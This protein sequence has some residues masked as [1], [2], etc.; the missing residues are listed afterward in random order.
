MLKRV[1]I[2]GI[3]LPRLYIAENKDDLEVAKSSGI[4]YIKWNK[5]VDE[6]V[7]QLL[8]PTL[9]KMFPGILWNKVLGRRRKFKTEVVQYPGG[10]VGSSVDP[11]SIDGMS[12]DDIVAAQM[13]CEPEII[14][15]D[16]DVTATRVADVA[17]SKRGFSGIRNEPRE[18]AV[19]DI[20]T[21]VGD[22]SS[23]VNLEVLQKLSLLPSFMGDIVDCIKRNISNRIRWTEGYNKKHALATGNFNASRELPNLIILDISGSIPDGISATMLT[24]ID[25]M[26]EELNADLII[27]SDISV[28]YK[29]GTELPSPQQLRASFGYGN[30]SYDFINILKKYIAGK[31]W[32]HVICFGDDDWPGFIKQEIKRRRSLTDIDESFM[33]GTKVH[34]VHHYHTGASCYRQ[35]GKNKRAGYAEWMYEIAD[36]RNLE[37]HFDTNWCEVM[38]KKYHLSRR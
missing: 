27:T 36:V 18:M 3:E 15:F 8:R 31:E 26:R 17:E 37:E 1:T 21:Y 4:P 14:D 22:L 2:D 38:N 19:Y 5:G 33:S 24:L 23:Q 34:A 7:R 10:D 20:E 11:E 30:E 13:S 16:D 29:Y 6:L 28:Y 35:I 12:N 32:G 25:T 9:E